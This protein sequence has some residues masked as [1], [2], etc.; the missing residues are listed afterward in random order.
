MTEPTICILDYGMGNLRSV[1]KALEHVGVRAL[2]SSNFEIACE[3]DG[4]ILP[5]V[6]AFPRAMSRVRELE[7][8]A[9]IADRR[10]AGVPILGVCLGLHLLFGSST[11]LGGDRGLGVFAG[12]VDELQAEDLK[13]PHIGWAEVRWERESEL[14]AG[15]QSETPFYFVHSFVPRPTHDEVLGTAVYGERFL[16]A[17]ESG[18]V[19]GVQ[20]HPE[21]SSA[22][23]L[24]LLRNFAG[25]CARAAAPAAA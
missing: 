7:L 12:G 5:G 8:D 15:I 13:V 1:E 2:R 11:E 24:Q 6:G 20:F 22:A 3:A 19:F 23:G 25:I 9:L 17:A 21:K 10:G 16:C 14:T 4:L 18:N